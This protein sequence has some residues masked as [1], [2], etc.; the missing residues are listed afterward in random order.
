MAFC[1]TPSVGR[2]KTALKSIF[3]AIG[4]AASSF[5][6]KQSLL[7]TISLTVRKPSFAIYSRSSSAI[8]RIKFSTY[9]G[10]PLKRFRSLGFC[11]AIPTGHVSRLQTRIIT[12]PIATSGA[13]AKPNSSAPSRAAIATSLPLI[14]FPSVSSFTQ[15]LNPFCKSV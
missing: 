1:G 9:S 8:K 15:F 7:P 13:V 4:D 6:F 14:N 10:F 5:T 12:Q 2:Y 3:C 11:V